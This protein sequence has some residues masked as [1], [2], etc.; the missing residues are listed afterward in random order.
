M[1]PILEGIA[2][3]AHVTDRLEKS[4]QIIRGIA[5]AIIG[6]RGGF[7][8]LFEL[9]ND[10]CDRWATGLHAAPQKNRVVQQIA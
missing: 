5:T 8:N 1:S 3:A 4:D 2:T 10:T 6:D 9:T 7:R